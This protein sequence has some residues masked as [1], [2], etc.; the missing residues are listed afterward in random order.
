MVTNGHILSS[1]NIKKIP[2][3]MIVQFSGESFTK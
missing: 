2:F 1:R 3:Q